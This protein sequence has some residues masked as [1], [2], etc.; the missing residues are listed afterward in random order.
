MRRL[1]S[2]VHK[3]SYHTRKVEGYNRVVNSCGN[4]DVF[5]HVSVW[6]RPSSKGRKH[7]DTASSYDD[8]TLAKGAT[9]GWREVLKSY[10]PGG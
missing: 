3:L 7:Q 2:R 10:N 6:M 4:G 8:S 1:F 9:R 5:P